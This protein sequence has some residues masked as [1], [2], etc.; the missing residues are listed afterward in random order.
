MIR[1]LWVS[2]SSRQMVL[3]CKEGSWVWTWISKRE[4]CQAASLVSSRLQIASCLPSVI[5]CDQDVS[6]NTPPF[7]P[8]YLFISIFLSQ[9]QNQTRRIVLVSF[10]CYKET[11]EI[12]LLSV[13]EMLR[14]KIQK[15]ALWSRYYCL[16]ITLLYSLMV[17][18]RKTMG[19]EGWTMGTRMKTLWT[20]MAESRRARDLS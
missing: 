16:L 17:E 11:H 2:S 13:L 14:S 15:M 7:F 5:D 10:C 19:L 6:Q 4:N 1:L 18:W 3:L 20:H 12:K 9:W 8:M